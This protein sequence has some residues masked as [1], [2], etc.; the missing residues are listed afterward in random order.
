MDKWH[1]IQREK[2]NY[3]DENEEHSLNKYIQFQITVIE[4][5][6]LIKLKKVRLK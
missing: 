2:V 1:Y 4:W 5:T 3:M 6:I